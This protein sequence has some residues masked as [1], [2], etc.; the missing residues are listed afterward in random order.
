MPYALILSEGSRD[1]SHNN[2]STYPDYM[3][4]RIL[5]T[6]GLCRLLHRISYTL[7]KT[8][9]VVTVDTET[10]GPETSGVQASISH[11]SNKLDEKRIINYC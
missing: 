5:C 10:D 4:C 9:R 7:P 1:F 8:I 6:E 3:A 2:Y 11:Y